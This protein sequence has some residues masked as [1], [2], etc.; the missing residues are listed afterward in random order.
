MNTIS[1]D[2]E[3]NQEMCAYQPSTSV[4]NIQPSSSGLQLSNA[5][6]A[7]SIEGST[8]INPIDDENSN[9]VVG[10]PLPRDV[11]TIHSTDKEDI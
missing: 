5:N 8:S 4:H 7:S 11:S 1:N 9:V 10:Q 6:I 2:T 3:S